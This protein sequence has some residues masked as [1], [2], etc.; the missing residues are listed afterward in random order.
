M[1]EKLPE[2]VSRLDGAG[3][4]DVHSSVLVL[5]GGLGGWGAGL[6]LVHGKGPAGC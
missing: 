6:E 5:A 4:E 2:G 1:A 3:A